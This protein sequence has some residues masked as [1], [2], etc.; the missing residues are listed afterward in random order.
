MGLGLPV[1]YNFYKDKENFFYK[2]KVNLLKTY[3]VKLMLSLFSRSFD[4]K[5]DTK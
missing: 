5:F 4:K 3:V 2:T 1:D